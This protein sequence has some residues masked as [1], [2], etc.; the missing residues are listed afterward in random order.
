MLK[1]LTAKS[2]GWRSWW[3][4][5]KFWQITE[6]RLISQKFMSTLPI[7]TVVNWNGHNG[8]EL[9]QLTWVHG[10]TVHF[11]SAPRTP[12]TLKILTAVY[13]SRQRH[14]LDGSATNFHSC[15]L[16]LPWEDFKCTTQTS[17]S[18]QRH[19]LSVNP[20]NFH[21]WASSTLCSTI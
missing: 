7:L 8:H 1:I 10:N 6:K 13:L 19:E 18:W 21:S 20:A 3:Q 2:A 9:W 16:A 11:D 14:G 15:Y 5:R 12:S 4:H 17:S